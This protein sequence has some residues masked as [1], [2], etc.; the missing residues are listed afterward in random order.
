VYAVVQDSLLGQTLPD[1]PE[2]WLASDALM[3]GTSLFD[4]F[5]ALPRPHT[6]DANAATMLDWISVPMITSAEASALLAGAPYATMDDLMAS[7][8]VSAGTRGRI[9][10]MAAAMDRLRTRGSDEEETLSLSTILVS[11]LWRL[12]VLIAGCTLGGA[13]LARRAGARRW[14]AAATIALGSSMLVIFAAW[15]VIGPAWLPFLVSPLLG[16][17]PL[18]AWRMFRRRQNHHAAEAMI[19]WAAASVPALL[20]IAFT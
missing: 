1:A 16:G 20:L 18:M 12:G 5:R 13:W 10:D 6:F 14:W 19:M 11:Y 2:I 17:V 4:Q 15:I 7:A 9:V 3:T 8:A